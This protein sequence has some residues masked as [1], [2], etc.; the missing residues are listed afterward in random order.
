MTELKEMWN[1][2]IMVGDFN[3]PPTIT[4]RITRFKTSS[5]T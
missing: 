1:Q 2:K 3:I 4:D 5:G